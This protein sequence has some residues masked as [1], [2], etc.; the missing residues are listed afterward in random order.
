MRRRWLFPFLLVVT[1]VL[2]SCEGMIEPQ[3][4]SQRGAQGLPVA[5]LG[6][7]TFV[8]DLNGEPAVTED[9]A[10]RE[11]ELSLRGID[12][13]VI[14]DSPNEMPPAASERINSPIASQQITPLQIT[15]LTVP[16]QI[17]PPSA[18][19]GTLPIA[20]EP[21]SLFSALGNGEPRKVQELSNP[22]ATSLSA[23]GEPSQNTAPQAPAWQV[24]DDR[25]P[26]TVQTP[27]GEPGA[28][29]DFERNE[30]RRV[31]PLPI[32][33]NQT[34]RRYVDAYLANFSGL[35]RSFERSTPYLAAMM[36]VLRNRGVPEEFVYLAFAESAF[37]PHAAGPWQLTKDTAR[38]FGLVIDSWVD[39]RRDPIKSTFA[40]AE[41]LSA[42][43]GQVGDWRLAVVGWNTGEGS[44]ERFIARRGL[45]FDRIS[46]RLPYRTISLLNRFMA[47]AF[48]AKELKNDD[49][50]RTAHQQ[51]PYATIKVRG[52]T[53][54]QEIANFARTSLETIRGLN[55]A[56]LQDVV[57][58]NDA[59]RDVVIPRTGI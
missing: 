33:M 2:S 22:Y 18:A 58:P 15:P 45:N 1:L 49:S 29:M 8:G 55:P 37:T 23:V 21:A 9:Q 27:G 51:S 44:V 52:G 46:R 31:A 16:E 34:V 6:D 54:L 42:L 43:H 14:A 40:A 47:V 41:F 50:I 4:F 48:L 30:P 26:N 25:S 11:V 3:P 53:P 32:L 36:Q 7:L 38:R 12:L 35:K 19:Q 59:A 20:E 17:T 39:E 24:V 56:L 28:S 5:P 57:P 13:A 10:R